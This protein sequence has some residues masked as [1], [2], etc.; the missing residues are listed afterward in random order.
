MIVTQTLAFDLLWENHD[1]D[2]VFFCTARGEGRPLE[3]AFHA[4]AINPLNSNEIFIYGGI[5][6]KGLY[7]ND[8]ILVDTQ[9]YAHPSTDSRF[10]SMLHAV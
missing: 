2:S 10:V 6:P 5:G 3:R 8:L 9:Q 4:S 7:L 1:Y